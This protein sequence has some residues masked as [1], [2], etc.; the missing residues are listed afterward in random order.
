MICV[1]HVDSNF[2]HVGVV[3][4]ALQSVVFLGVG[5]S[6]FFLAFLQ[7]ADILLDLKYLYLVVC[8]SLSREGHHSLNGI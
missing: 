7:F 5:S 8:S 6:F 4:N 2:T 3:Q 1:P